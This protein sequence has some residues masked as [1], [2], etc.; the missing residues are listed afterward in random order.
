MGNFQ[1]ECRDNY[2]SVMSIP[3]LT[4]VKRCSGFIRARLMWWRGILY[5][6]AWSEY[7]LWDP[8]ILLCLLNGVCLM[9]SVLYCP[10]LV[11]NKLSD[12]ELVTLSL[13]YDNR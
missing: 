1:P 8:G 12:S 6:P 7:A 4:V 3:V 9:K 2:T 5:S 10:S 11:I 13:Y